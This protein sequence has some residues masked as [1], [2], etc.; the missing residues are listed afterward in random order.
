MPINET[1]SKK[2]I[3]GLSVSS[4]LSASVNYREWVLERASRKIN[5]LNTQFI[6]KSPGKF[7]HE[8]RLTEVQVRPQEPTAAV[9]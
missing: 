3:A 1:K 5:D 9:A 6:S 7:Y 2:T 8:K 4:V